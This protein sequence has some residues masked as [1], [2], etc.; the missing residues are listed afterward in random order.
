MLSLTRSL[1]PRFQ[2]AFPRFAKLTLA[3]RWLSIQTATTPNENSLKFIVK[4]HHF[5][6]PSVDHSVDVED[7][8][9]ASDK[10]PLAVSLFK[11][12]GVMSLLIGP[13]FITVNKV[14]DDLSNNPELQWPALKPKIIDTLE[15]AFKEKTPVLTTEYIRELE[16]TQEEPQDE[17]DDV[18]YEIK[19]LLNTRIRPALQDDGGDVHFR[20]FDPHT[21]TVYIKLKGA[22]KSCS[23]SEETLKNGIESMLKYYVEEVNEVKPI[24]DLEEEVSLQEFEKLEA[25]LKASSAT[26]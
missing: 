2:G 1:T 20:S 17:D 13:D 9:A 14:E 5:L 10:S 26:R 16:R 22:C 21:G 11:L 18:T 12:N 15:T 3:A 23:L 7:L 8:P 25:K 6:P 24:L 4:D 19:E